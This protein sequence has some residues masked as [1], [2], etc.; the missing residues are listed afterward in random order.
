MNRQAASPRSGR[1]KNRGMRLGASKV[2]RTEQGRLVLARTWRQRLRG[3]L[4]R[5]RPAV[6]TALL[7]WPCMAVHSLGMTHALDVY[8]LDE[9]GRCVKRVRAM[10]PWRCA[11]HP[12]AVAVLE[13]RAGQAWPG[14]WNDLGPRL[15]RILRRLPRRQGFSR[16]CWRRPPDWQRRTPSRS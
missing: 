6:V 13:L 3:W 1:D 10:Q 4:W 11:W 15:R 7:L 14:G 9:Q 5:R 12:R 2:A 16:W 8:F